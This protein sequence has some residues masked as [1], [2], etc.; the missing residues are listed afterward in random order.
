MLPEQAGYC[1]SCGA[2]VV[3]ERFT[4]RILWDEVVEKFLGWDTTFLTTFR[5]LFRRPEVVL[6]AYV[7]QGLRKRYMNPFGFYAIGVAIMVFIITVFQEDYIVMMEQTI[8]TERNPIEGIDKAAFQRKMNAWMAK[9]LNFVSFLFLPIYSFLSW[10][11]FR[12]K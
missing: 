12:K 4:M 5:E 1:S 3:R 11:L 8:I 9:Y 10:V 2:R 6:N 7:L